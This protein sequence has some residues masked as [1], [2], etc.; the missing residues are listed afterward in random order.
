MDVYFQ[1]MA[2]RNCDYC[3]GKL[4]LSLK[5]LP[6]QFFFEKQLK[7]E[8]SG[9]TLYQETHIISL[10]EVQLY[11]AIISLLRYIQL[12]LGFSSTVPLVSCAFFLEQPHGVV[13]TMGSFLS[14]HQYFVSVFLKKKRGNTKTP[15][16]DGYLLPLACKIKMTK[17]NHS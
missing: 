17:F 5:N 15:L 13:F 2:I 3:Q 14:V 8:I 11:Q 7:Q 10:G 1:N 9:D 4:R 6:Y 12:K 16:L